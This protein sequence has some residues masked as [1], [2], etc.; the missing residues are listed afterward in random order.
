M[1]WM[2]LRPGCLYLYL[3]HSLSA[4]LQCTDHRGTDRG[5]EAD[6]GKLYIDTGTPLNTLYCVFRLP[7]FLFGHL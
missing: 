1:F 4:L 2:K 3:S 6:T 5:A 7:D